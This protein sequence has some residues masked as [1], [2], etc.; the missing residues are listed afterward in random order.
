MGKRG[1]VMAPIMTISY[2]LR[3]DNYDN[4]NTGNNYN[5]NDNNNS[6]DSDNNDNDA[7]N[8]NGNGNCNSNNNYGNNENLNMYNNKTILNEMKN[9]GPCWSSEFLYK[10]V[11]TL[12]RTTI[13]V[14]PFWLLFISPSFYRYYHLTSCIVASWLACK[15]FHRVAIINYWINFHGVANV[16]FDSVI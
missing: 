11:R 13:N 5:E 6:N 15:A 3:V 1:W 7:D 9:L 16:P 12:H 4:N 8:D 10:D 14:R 2:H